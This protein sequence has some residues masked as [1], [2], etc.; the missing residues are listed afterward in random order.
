MTSEVRVARRS[1]AFGRRPGRAGTLRAVRAADAARDD[2]LE[3]AGRYTFGTLLRQWRQRQGFSQLDLAAEASISARHL[4]FLENGRARPSRDMLKTLAQVLDVPTRGR[5]ELLMAAGFAPI[6]RET[7]LEEPTMTQARRALQLTLA[8]QEPYPAV[9]VDRLWNIV[10]ANNGMER[11]TKLLLS[12]D[13]AQEAG[14]PNLMH[15]TYHPCGLRRFIA[16][17]EETASAYIQWLHRDALRTG[18]PEIGRLLDEVLAYP[19]VP[20][21][22]LAFDLSASSVPFL[23]IEFEKDD[24]RLRFFTTAASFGTAYDI[25]LH[26]LRVECFFPADERTEVEMRRIAAA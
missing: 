16:N 14:A 6:Y 9:V 2:P 17:W 20:R 26:E 21:D 11:V 18:D 22:L 4:S 19:D 25:T 7:S 3:G 8:Q 13:E 5:N 15:L 12:P 10:L 24:L 1:P 23:T